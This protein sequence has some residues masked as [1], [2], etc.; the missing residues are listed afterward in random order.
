[1]SFT[2]RPSP[3]PACSN[4]TEFCEILMECIP[5]TQICPNNTFEASVSIHIDGPG[6]LKTRIEQNAHEPNQYL[7]KFGVFIN[8]Q[9]EGNQGS[10]VSQVGVLEQFSN[11]TIPMQFNWT[12]LKGHIL[13][14]D[15]TR[16]DKIYILVQAFDRRFSTNVRPLTVQ[17]IGVT[18][19]NRMISSTC[20]INDASGYC[21]GS[22]VDFDNALNVNISV[23]EEH[24][25][26]CEH[27]G[28]VVLQAIE[29]HEVPNPAIVL[30]VPTHTI[31]PPDTV[32]ITVNSNN[33]DAKS[34]L[35]DCSV[36]NEYASI[37]V[38]PLYGWSTL[39]SPFLNT[40]NRLA[41]SHERII[42][43][44]ELVLLSMEVNISN[45]NEN[46]IEVKCEI[47][48]LLLSNG[49]LL[50]NPVM[51]VSDRTGTRNSIGHLFLTKDDVVHLVAYSNQTEL[52]NSAVFNGTVIRTNLT[53]KGVTKSGRIV[54]LNNLNCSSIPT[55]IQV[56]PN[57]SEVFL[58][59]TEQMGSNE[60]NVT[61]TYRNIDPVMVSFKVWYPENLILQAKDTVLN[62]ISNWPDPNLNCSSRYQQ[63]LL[64]VFANVSDGRIQ[65][66]LDVTLLAINILESSDSSIIKI[67]PNAT[68]LGIS[69]G[70][71][72][73]HSRENNPDVN[74]LQFNVTTVSV[75]AAYL[76]VM[77]FSNL[78]VSFSPTITDVYDQIS[79]TVSLTEV[80][81]NPKV[82]LVNI[83]FTDSQRMEI[84]HSLYQ[85][86]CTCPQFISV[87]QNNEIHTIGTGSGEC[88]RV[89][90]LRDRTC[91]VSDNIE[92]TAN[93]SVHL[94]Q[95]SN[96][97]IRMSSSQ[98]TADP[99]V[100]S[101]ANDCH[102]C[103]DSPLQ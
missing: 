88:I 79:A 21:I 6:F 86:N 92:G 18:N 52:F 8:V 74:I 78:D 47:E 91:N 17:I 28:L 82:M 101:L 44:G 81:Y 57:C 83:V 11:F 23:K 42:N 22:L 36:N 97:E 61:I 95:S 99:Y 40:S 25:P 45:Y 50:E 96:L 3:T 75:R 77:L 76:E 38:S 27:V 32:T 68:V 48:E 24:N 64:Q 14:H 34:L 46:Q 63:T 7:F 72:T 69:P 9:Q 35:L 39:T 67:F 19:T 51:M 30:N 90:L 56:M 71:A 54:D 13:T 55:I 43:N 31:Y 41:I 16:D 49:V 100:S 89:T 103:S 15:V 33:Y 4:D 94:P 10:I 37:V 20:S 58:D 70:I 53:I 62:S 93:V 87:T 5:C 29:S 12:R 80:N 2:A 73:I 85:V 66:L 65:Y 60:V 84:G 102:H 98:I 59:G 26:H 1:M